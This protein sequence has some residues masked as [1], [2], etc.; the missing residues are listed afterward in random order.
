M[1]GVL[2][3]RYVAVCHSNKTNIWQR[4]ITC[5]VMGCGGPY[6]M[7]CSLVSL[8]NLRPALFLLQLLVSAQQKTKNR[9]VPSE[10]SEPYHAVEIQDKT[11][12]SGECYSKM[13]RASD[14]SA[15][16]TRFRHSMKD[17]QLQATTLPSSFALISCLNQ[18][19]LRAD[20]QLATILL[21]A[22]S[23]VKAGFFSATNTLRRILASSG[24]R[25]I[26]SR[27]SS[28]AGFRV[29]AAWSF[30]ASFA[31]I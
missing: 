24:S 28:W 2:D 4:T 15:C 11:K 31:R 1:T 16:L 19:V 5:V 26:I 18:P 23:I 8:T 22:T 14:F 20:L 3:P 13:L 29:M 9:T 21:Q 7:S 27:R 30:W 10:L 17:C 25:D 6:K 12:T